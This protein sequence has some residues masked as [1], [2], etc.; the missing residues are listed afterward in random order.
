MALFAQVEY[1]FFTSPKLLAAAQDL[2]ICEHKLGGH[3]IRLWSWAMEHAEDGNLSKLSKKDIET[4]SGWTKK[5]G[6]LI[7]NLIKFEFVDENSMGLNLHDWFEHSGKFFLR[8]D[9]NK[10]YYAETKKLR[11]QQDEE[12][13]SKISNKIKE[14]FKN[15]LSK[16]SG[17][18]K[19]NLNPFSRGILTEPNLTELTNTGELNTPLPPNEIPDTISAVADVAAVAPTTQGKKKPY[20]ELIIE[21]FGE[22][23]IPFLTKEKQK[24][25]KKVLSIPIDKIIDIWNTNKHNSFASIKDI[26]D[27]R[28]RAY[29]KRLINFNT[30]EQWI[31]A[32]KNL[33]NWG[34]A[35]GKN[36]SGWLGTF[37][38]LLS[39]KGI[40]AFE[41]KLANSPY[42]PKRTL[43]NNCQ[44]GEDLPLPKRV[45]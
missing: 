40:K 45:F 17:K 20:D 25:P 37:D 32:I 23:A 35:Q 14:D 42:D 5:R 11:L 22:K 33:S 21:K 43:M 6:K 12:K 44:K 41:G 8:K 18:I 19:E 34:F 9:Y 2:G 29:E 36:D 39:E 26:T 4:V 16:N 1:A 15:G 7:E 38:Y 28:L 24:K 3:I 30:E 13:L 31:I 27:K 10:R